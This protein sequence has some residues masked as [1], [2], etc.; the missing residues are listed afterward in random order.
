MAAPIG[1][2]D[3]V[4]C[5]DASLRRVTIASGRL[6]RGAIYCVAWCAERHATGVGLVQSIGLTDP[7]MRWYAEDGT[8]GGYVADRFRPIYRPKQELIQSLKAPPI[9]AP[10]RVS[11][12]A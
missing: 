9:N 11:E 10:A 1:P 4:E 5:V 6:V 3:W 12:D 8:E 2:G 7:V